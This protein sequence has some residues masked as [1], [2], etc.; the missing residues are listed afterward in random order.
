M[1]N[2]K[3]PMRYNPYLGPMNIAIGEIRTV[4]LKCEN[5]K[6]VLE[7]LFEV[8]RS[9][10]RIFEIVIRHRFDTPEYYIPEFDT[11]IS[12]LYIK[13][14][15]NDINDIMNWYFKNYHIGLIPRFD[16]CKTFEDFVQKNS[17]LQ[18]MV[19]GK[20]ILIANDVNHW[21]VLAPFVSK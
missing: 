15:K 2:K 4:E 1:I 17:W 12:Q 16:K 10:L 3:L 8:I 21:R 20:A 9:N 7:I 13:D 14:G 19:G 6:V 11:P 5:K 18:K